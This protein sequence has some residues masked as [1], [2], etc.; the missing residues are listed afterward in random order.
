VL[1]FINAEIG[2]GFTVLLPHDGTTQLAGTGSWTGYGLLGFNFGAGIYFAA[3]GDNSGIHNGGYVSDPGATVDTGFIDLS[4]YAQPEF[5]TAA[6][7][8]LPSLTGADP[9]DMVDGTFQVQATDLSLGTTEPHGLS[10][11][12]YYNS[13]RRNSSLVGISPGW[14]HNYYL[15]ASTVSAPQASLGETTAAQMAP[16]LVATA[17]ANGIFEFN[18][19]DP[20]NWMTTVLIAKWGIDQVTGKAVSVT[21]GKDVVQFIEQP[22]GS[23]TPPANSTMTLTQ[24]SGAYTVQERHGR[25]FQFNSA[26]WC[27]NI[28]DPYNNSL[29][30]TYNSS[31][32]VTG[33]T[34]ST[35]RTLTF[36]Y[37]TS[38]PKR[39]TNVVDSASRSV[40][41]GYSSGG[42]LNAVTDP[43]GKTS[44]F[45]YDTNHQIIATSNALGQLVASNIYN[46]FGRVTKQ[47][48]EGSSSKEWQIFWD[49][50]QTV[51][52]NPQGGQRT[53]FFD[54]K[55]R[56]IGLQ[57]AVGNL[58]QQFYDGQDH[59]VLTVSPLGETNQFIYDGNNNLVETIDP[60]G[61]S[62]QFV[63]DSQNR[64]TSTI[65]PLGHTSS[66][67]YNSQFS[68]TGYTNGNGDWHVLAYNS[69]GTAAS[70]QDAAGTTSYSY[71]TH[72][73]L[74]GISYPGSL[75]SESFVNNTFGD[76]TSHTDARGF[77]TTFAY[78]QRRQLIN[79]VAP[80]NLTTSMAYDAEG[81]LVTNTDAR[82]NKIVSFW[83]P[84]QQRTGSV[85]PSTPQGNP[86]IT[87]L[88]D[89]R[90]WLA[91]SANPL[92]K[93]T[94]FTNDAAHRVTA[95]RDPLTRPTTLAYDAD[96]HQT[97]A[98]DAASET[99][100]Q[101]FDPR[102]NV[103]KVTDA[104]SH[105]VGKT[106]DGAGNLT[107][108]TNRND[109]VWTFQY[110]GAN[111][112]TNT[113]SPTGKA[114][115]QV[116]N[117]WGLLQSTTDPL[118][119]TTSFVYDARGR[120]TNMTDNQGTTAYV[121]DPNGNITNTSLNGQTLQKTFDAYNRLVAYTD[122]NGYTIQYRHDANGNVTS[123]IYPGGPTVNY[124]YDSYN[125][126]TNVTDW[127]SLQTS[128]AYDLA[129]QVTNLSRPNNTER[130]V[131]Y[132]ADGEITNIVDK[133]TSQ[134]PIA[135]FV[136]NYDLAGRVQWEFKGPPPH[137]ATPTT[138]T[139]AYDADNRLTNFNGSGVTVDAN[140][141]MT[142][143]PG[144][145]AT[146]LTYT[147]DCLNRLTSV[148]GISYGYD[149]AN[150][151][152]SQ[153]NGAAVT[154]YVI[155][156]STSQVLMRVRASQT[157][158]YIYG[159]GLVYEI[160]VSGAITSTFFYHFDSR[161]STVTLTDAN[162]NPTDIVEYSAYGCTTY[163]Y[164]S[165]DTPFLYNGR[166]GVQ[167]DTNGLLY[168][169]AR[170]YN[171]YICRFLN[172]DPSGFK[173]GLNFYQFANGNPISMTDPFG[174]GAVG[175]SGATA[176]MWAGATQGLNDLLGGSE[177]AQRVQDVIQGVV[178][179]ATF[180]V[181]GNLAQ[182]NDAGAIAEDALDYAMI[183]ANLFLAAATDG[184][185]EEAE[186][187]AGAFMEVGNSLSTTRNQAVFWSGIPNGAN[188]A[189]QWAAGNAG[190]TLEQTIAA[191]GIQLPAWDA[192]NAASVAAWSQASQQ[193]AAGA[194]GDI[195]VLQGD[196]LRIKSVWGQT[197]YS[198]LK[199]NPNVTSITAVN[200]NTGE[201]VLLWSR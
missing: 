151:R 71:D 134:F 103:V 149:P 24:S 112:L 77:T 196:A 95:S 102:G 99:T 170:Y 22:D 97:A 51:E 119:Q 98:T 111:R 115:S 78:N 141:N 165:H 157:N 45:L 75:G 128:Y 126:L 94:Y 59:I 29:Q 100:T 121:R 137:A 50:W 30:L 155:D 54:D 150:N 162:G 192:N 143:G 139:M 83:S 2:Q 174:L 48:T 32:W 60:L 172:P 175:E 110:D 8:S 80:T 90:D 44:T 140:G 84:T 37:K 199:A 109:K 147:Y 190:V 11:S 188:S 86:T 197:E 105:S 101:V 26:G 135:F 65:D 16:L 74:S 17:A 163:R 58:S 72:G 187:E 41:I 35:G 138:R 144:T 36:Q 171:P 131:A 38:T 185:S 9:V 168:M 85:Y 123:L 158:Y 193:F 40:G 182:G 145:N 201:R 169:R 63:Y 57:N 191:R 129:G 179:F 113:T 166:E 13:S 117:N 34:D 82:G 159:N 200:P 92:G 62:N 79:I 69:D 53:F 114:T 4:D 1:G 183:D 116:Y 194:S 184:L 161:G 177:V 12:R 107:Y 122:V 178:N 136:L 133:A 108:L 91:S 46:G 127:N 106:Y 124:Y 33:V 81:N 152:V 66:F 56:Q 118:A 14:V 6:S 43:E 18:T 173:G 76:A 28:V 148:G 142:S 176:S 21:L 198:A 164:G 154:S 132:D 64:L 55:S 93:I 181:A 25:T 5:F 31:N 19:P 89:T 3:V 15:N 20:N 42:D 87:N 52:Q 61:F 189:A 7:P 39:L 104:T 120:M 70:S 68:V 10:F 130:S 23:Y 67:G 186:L 47:F 27:T 160:D 180:G 49:G 146:F 96:D 125:R 73:T 167:T 153:T 156:P 195:T 88:Y